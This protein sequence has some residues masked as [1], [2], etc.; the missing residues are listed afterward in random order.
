MDA[1]KHNCIAAHL[2]HPLGVHSKRF[3]FD[4]EMLRWKVRCLALSS[5]TCRDY[6]QSHMKSR[7]WL[8]G[9]DLWKSRVCGSSRGAPIREQISRL[10]SGAHASGKM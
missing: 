5:P 3:D 4:Y 9:Y 2:P 10:R 6:C 1:V 8:E 7:P